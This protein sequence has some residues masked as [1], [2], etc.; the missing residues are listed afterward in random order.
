[1]TIVVNEGLSRGGK[2]GPSGGH[3]D[4]YEDMA[5]LSLVNEAL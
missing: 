3:F 4:D 2:G 1:M 5:R